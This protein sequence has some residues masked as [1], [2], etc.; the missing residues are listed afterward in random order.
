MQSSRD[1]VPVRGSS[2]CSRQP[3]GGGGASLLAP[4]VVQPAGPGPAMQALGAPSRTSSTAH[5]DLPPVA[6]LTVGNEPAQAE[7][8]DVWGGA[9]AFTVTPMRNFSRLQQ[10]RTKLS[11]AKREREGEPSSPRWSQL[12]R[13]NS[14]LVLMPSEGIGGPGVRLSVLRWQLLRWASAGTPATQRRLRQRGEVPHPL[15]SA[16][17]LG[18]QAGATPFNPGRG[19]RRALGASES[20]DALESPPKGKDMTDTARRIISA[21]DTVA[22]SL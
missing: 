5:K 21:L 16:E 10:D 12:R 2:S 1:C 9:S 19:L 11:G 7:R 14:T 8:E 22:V 15:G 20:G 13:H 17:R 4:P 18:W 3:F 6:A